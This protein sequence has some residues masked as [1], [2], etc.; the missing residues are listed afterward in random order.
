VETEVSEEVAH[1]AEEETKRELEERETR[2]IGSQSP[3]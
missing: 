1:K 2:K 3:N